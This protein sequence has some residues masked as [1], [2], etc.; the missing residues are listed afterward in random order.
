MKIGAVIGFF[1]CVGNE[2]YKMMKKRLPMRRV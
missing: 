1:R 2:R